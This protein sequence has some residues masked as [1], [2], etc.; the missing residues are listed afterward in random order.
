MPINI[1]IKAKLPN[2]EETVSRATLL[3]DTPREI[4]HQHDTFYPTLHGRLKLRRFPDGTGE[5]IYYERP[6]QEGPK[7]SLFDLAHTED[8][9][10]LHTVLAAAHGVRGEVIKERWLYFAGQTRIHLDQV[11]GLG[12]FLELEVVLNDGQPITDGEAIAQ[13]LMKELG[14][15]PANLIEGAYM[16][17][18]DKQ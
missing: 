7:T 16:D 15:D 4:I 5:L 12:T 6:D 17:M 1:E 2:F 8:A 11:E 13:R 9:S 10:A 18:L 3:S 14:V